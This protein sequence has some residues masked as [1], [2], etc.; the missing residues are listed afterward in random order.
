MQGHSDVRP[1]TVGRRRSV[2]RAL[3]CPDAAPRRRRRRARG[4]ATTRAGPSPGT[5]SAWSAAT[6]RR[7]VRRMPLRRRSGRGD[8]A[9]RPSTPAPTCSSRTTRCC[10]RP[11]HGVPAT[12]PKGRLVHD[13]IRS[14]TRA[15][16]RAH[17]RRRRAT[18]G[19]RCAGDRASGCATCAPLEPS[20]APRAGQARRRS[21][22]ATTPRGSRRAGR[23]RRRGD[24]RLRPVR[25]ARRTAPG[26]S[27]PALDA[28]ARDRRRRRGDGRRRDPAGDGGC[29]AG[30]GRRCSPRSGRRTPTRSRRSTSSSWPAQ[31]GDA[32]SA[33]S[34]CCPNRCRFAEFAAAGR[35]PAAGRSGRGPRGR[36]PG[37]RR[38]GPSRSAAVRATRC[39]TRSPAAGVDAFVTAD[40]RHHPAAEHSRRAARRWSTPA[41]GPP[42]GPGWPTRPRRLSAALGE[43]TVETAVS[44]RVTDPWTVCS[45]PGSP[46]PVVR[47]EPA[48]N[49]D[50]AAQLR[51]LDL[52]ALDTAL[53][54][55]AHRRATLPEL[56]EHRRA[57]DA[58]PTCATDIVGAETEVSD[59][60]REQRGPTATSSR[61]ARAPQPRPARMDSGAVAGQ[62][63]GEP[64]ARGRHARPPPGRRWRTQSS[65]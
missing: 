7:Q 53:D 49:A 20:P 51:L 8:R 39:S 54:Q 15:V 26:R 35:R 18:R 27:A 31:P 52:Q 17:Q 16:R 60:D 41:T 2:P 14:G 36:R 32:G 12:T 9:T 28:R 3:A 6:R 63:A 47:K 56:A 50:P 10:C 45:A 5:R 11:V 38:C 22:R 43:A 57:D 44:A 55:L 25:L 61:C 21:C 48:V 40:L 34:A 42:S 62:G 4:A 59:L 65:R 33:G 64:A 23:R 19:L 37:P 46:R 29:R 58:S 24:R 30:G 13:L 1:G